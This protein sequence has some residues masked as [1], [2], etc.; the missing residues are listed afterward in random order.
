M[1]IT[2]SKPS[3]FLASAFCLLGCQFNA[4]ASDV[5]VKEQSRTTSK[6]TSS[7]SQLVYMNA[8]AIQC[9]YKG[10]TLNETAQ[11]LNEKDID[12]LSSQC[13]VTN[14]MYPSVCGAGNGALN[15]HRINASN[16]ESAKT[17]GFNPVSELENSGVGYQI[18]DCDR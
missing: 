12:V 16:L 13:G 14:M 2:L 7:D 8:G 1:G 4:N 18:V 9:E 17:I 6:K 10:K 11:L 5:V 3:W 15:L